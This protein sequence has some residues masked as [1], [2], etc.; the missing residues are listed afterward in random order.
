VIEAPGSLKKPAAQISD[1]AGWGD[2]ERDNG[3]GDGVVVYLEGF[4]EWE[5]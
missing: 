5:V 1:D 3:Y 4:N 2:V